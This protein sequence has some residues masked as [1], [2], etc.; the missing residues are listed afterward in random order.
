[1]SQ[2]ALGILLAIIFVIAAFGTCGDEAEASPRPD[3]VEVVATTE[4]ERD[5]PTE[6]EPEREIVFYC[7]TVWT[8]TTERDV[9][10]NDGS[11][12]YIYPDRG[13][14]LWCPED[15]V[16]EYY[17][18]VAEAVE[19]IDFYAYC[20]YGQITDGIPLP[21]AWGDDWT[22]FIFGMDDYIHIFEYLYGVQ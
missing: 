11:H 21:T 12:L 15:N 20:R 8:T 2:K 10:F 18:D 5:I 19:A 4:G 17:Y 6:V 1:M 22:M 7:Y 9:K 13:L 14:Y 3:A 16:P